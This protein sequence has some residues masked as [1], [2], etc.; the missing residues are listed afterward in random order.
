MLTNLGRQRFV[1]QPVEHPW[2]G[3]EFGVDTAAV[4]PCQARCFTDQNGGAPFVEQPTL[5]QV[6]RVWHV[7][8]QSVRE[9]DMGV[10]PSR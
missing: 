9:P 4:F 6:Q 2:V 8:N 3:T 5:Q 10:T 1:T 7:L